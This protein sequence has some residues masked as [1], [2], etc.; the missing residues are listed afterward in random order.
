[1]KILALILALGALTACANSQSTIK[2]EQTT[3]Q[4]VDSVINSPGG[5]TGY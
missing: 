4:F 5:A 3:A 2:P 1:M